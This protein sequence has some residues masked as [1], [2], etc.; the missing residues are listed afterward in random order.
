MIG[1]A[2]F[3]R[4]GIGVPVVLLALFLLVDPSVARSIIDRL[5]GRHL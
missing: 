2:T 1:W 5:P 3:V 4:V